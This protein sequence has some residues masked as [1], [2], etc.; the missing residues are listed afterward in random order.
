LLSPGSVGLPYEGQ[1]GAAYWALLGPG[2]DFR[3]TE[4]EIEAAVAR[5]RETDDP[6]VDVI[7]GMMLEPPSREEVIE[8][9][10]RLVFAG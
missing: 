3:R 4:Y 8:N 2:V 6:R 7:A 9:A 1:A 5:M 10:E